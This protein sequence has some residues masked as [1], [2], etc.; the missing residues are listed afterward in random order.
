MDTDNLFWLNNTPEK[1]S[2]MLLVILSIKQLNRARYLKYLDFK[3]YFAD[4]EII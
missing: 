3:K 1:V 2:L 4:R